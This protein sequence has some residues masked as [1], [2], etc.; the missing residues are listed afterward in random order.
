[1]LIWLIGIPFF[2][3]ILFQTKRDTDEGILVF[4]GIIWPL[5]ILVSFGEV[6]GLLLRKVYD[7]ASTR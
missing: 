5:T 3:G 7:Y 1:M 6:I 2:T 4:A